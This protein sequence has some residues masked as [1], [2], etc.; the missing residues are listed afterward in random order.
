MLTLFTQGYTEMTVDWL[1]AKIKPMKKAAAGLADRA[2][3]VAA[4]QWLAEHDEPRPLLTYADGRV[5]S[6]M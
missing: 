4:L 2:T 3:L 6:L 1:V 5:S